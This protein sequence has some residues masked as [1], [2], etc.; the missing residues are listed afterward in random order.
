MLVQY[1]VGNGTRCCRCLARRAETDTS[2][3]RGC[4]AALEGTG[5][6]S[7]HHQLE[8]Q[9]CPAEPKRKGNAGTGSTRKS[10]VL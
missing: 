5:Q 1:N 9:L 7:Q 8:A 3:L 10:S 4:S 2:V 6:P